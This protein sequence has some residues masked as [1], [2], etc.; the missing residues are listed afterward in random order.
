MREDVIKAILIDFDGVLTIDK[1]G[2]TT[3]TRYIAHQTG[4]PLDL[5]KESYYKHN[6]KLLLGELTHEEI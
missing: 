3:T 1:T 2:S 4:I 6:K 5:V